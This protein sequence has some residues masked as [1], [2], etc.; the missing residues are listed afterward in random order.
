MRNQNQFV[1]KRPGIF[2]LSLDKELAWG[3]FHLDGLRLFRAHFDQ[4]RNLVRKLLAL[5]DTYEIPATWAFVGH[6][7]LEQCH[8]PSGGTTHPDVLRPQYDWY[9]EDWHHC[10]PATNVHRDPCWYGPDILEMVLSARANHEVGTHT[11]SHVIVGDPACT[12]EIFRSQLAACVDLH[13]RSGLELHSI[14]F[15]RNSIGHLEVLTEFGITNYRGREQRWYTRLWPREGGPLHTLDRTIPTPPTTYPLEGLSEG[16]LV[17]L[18]ASM[19]L[20][21]RDGFRRYIPMQSRVSQMQ[22]GLRRAAERGEL[23][24]LWFHP[25]N[26]G[27][28]PRLFTALEQTFQTACDLRANGQLEILTMQQAAERVRQTREHVIY[29][30]PRQPQPDNISADQSAYKGIQCKTDSL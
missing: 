15:P 1:G 28:D 7:L 27:S 10:D 23:F 30:H 24:H 3:T 26:L 20:V 2:V 29:S 19:F 25:F 9:T 6:L 16:K 14:V 12:A 22:S 17:N 4:S 18:P 8:R 21:P 5:L 13:R 11:F